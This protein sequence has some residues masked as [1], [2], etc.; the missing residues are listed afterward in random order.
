MGWLIAGKGTPIRH[1]APKSG[2]SYGQTF[3]VESMT[4]WDAVRMLLEKY[5][6]VR[7]S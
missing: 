7:V 1:F 6:A 2:K 5:R 4:L 3:Q